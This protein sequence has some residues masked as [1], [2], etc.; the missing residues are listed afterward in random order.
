MKI[1]AMT[2]HSLSLASLTLP[3]LSDLKA[4]DFTKIT[5]GNT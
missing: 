2:G 4:E 5:T 1:T 3:P